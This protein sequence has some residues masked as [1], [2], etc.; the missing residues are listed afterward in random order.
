[1]SQR[2]HHEQFEAVDQHELWF[3]V[4]VDNPRTACLGPHVQDRSRHV[5]LELQPL[6]LQEHDWWLQPTRFSSWYN[7]QICAVCW[8]FFSFL[9]QAVI[10]GR[11]ECAGY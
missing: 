9:Y 6:V 8:C 4:S 3:E 10:S 7:F 2:L 1:M 11:G 5:V